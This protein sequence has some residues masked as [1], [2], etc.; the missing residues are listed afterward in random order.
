MTIKIKKLYNIFNKGPVQPHFYKSGAGFVMLFAVTLSSILLAIALGVANIAL[1]EVTFSTLAESTNNAFVAA[2]TGAECTLFYDK[3][4]G[5][6][7]PLAG[8]ATAISC[9]SA[10]PSFSGTA[11]TGSYDFIITGLGSSGTSCT[12]VNVFK[13]KS[14]SPTLVTITSTGYDIGDA[15][16]NSTNPNR[17][18]RQLKIT[19]RLGVPSSNP[20]PSINVALA[21]NGGTALASST[22]SPGY[23][24]SF[25]VNGERT[26]AVWGTNG[27][28]NDKTNNSWPDWL[29]VDFN[30][31]KTINEIDIFSVQDNYLSPNTPTSSMTFTL[32]GLVNFRVQYWDGSAWQT[33]PGGSISGNNLVWRQVTFPSIT[34]T[35]IRV[36]VTGVMPGD[37]WSRVT[38]V[39]AWGN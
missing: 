4:T 37:V 12:K 31:S 24:P 34:T 15:S 20:P 6:S 35:R 22:Y 19:S 13:D 3:L 25:T 5:S 1:K 36:N 10:L 9:A 16:C 14:V 38:E 32:Y 30:G 8:P 29:K 28:W 39:E 2:D 11:N 23:S 27:G 33:V 18:E 7:F 17:V 26:G 21:S